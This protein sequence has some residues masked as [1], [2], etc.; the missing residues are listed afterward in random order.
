[1]GTFVYNVSVSVD[2]EIEE[3]WHKWMQNTHIPEVMETGYFLAHEFF[4]VLLNREE[5]IVTY[6]IQYRFAEMKDLQL[7]QA[8]EA[9]QLQ[10]KH[11]ERYGDKCVA[12]RT[13][14]EKIY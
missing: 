4:K 14:L 8:K 7:Y 11:L 10:A 1:M 6:S 3:D 13:V 9:P 2:L 5:G 12:F